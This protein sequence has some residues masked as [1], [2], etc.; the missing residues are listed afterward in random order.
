MDN[1]SFKNPAY[2][3]LTN[4]QLNEIDALGGQLL[5]SVVGLST[6]QVLFRLVFVR[7]PVTTKAIVFIE[8]WLLGSLRVHFGFNQWVER[9]YASLKLLDPLSLLANDLVAWLEHD[10]AWQIVYTPELAIIP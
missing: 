6:R 5:F 3:A 10:N 1:P 4:Q 9:Q 8:D 2:Q 7:L